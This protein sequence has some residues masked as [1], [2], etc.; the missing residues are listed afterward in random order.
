VAPGV[1]EQGDQEL[2]RAVGDEALLGEGR[3]AVDEAEQ[4]DDARDTPEVDDD[5]IRRAQRALWT[6]L[7]VVAEPGA[8][9]PLAALLS[10]AYRP[11]QGERVG[12][13]VSGGNTTV[14]DL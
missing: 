5:A 13:V 10:G 4:L 7:R 11:A 3:R 6:A 2:R 12:V 9:A 14:V 1:A 8:A